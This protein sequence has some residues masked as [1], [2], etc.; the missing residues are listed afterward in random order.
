MEPNDMKVGKD[1]FKWEEYE[2]IDKAQWEKY[3]KLFFQSF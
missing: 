2:K 3:I 1:I